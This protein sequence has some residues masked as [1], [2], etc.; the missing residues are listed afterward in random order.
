VD[1]LA[2]DF[3]EGIVDETRAG[4]AK[5]I[6]MELHAAGIDLTDQGAVQRWIGSRNARLAGGEGPGRGV[7]GSARRKPR[8]R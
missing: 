8:R 5:Q 6:A 4:P 7:R 1:R 2:P 3:L